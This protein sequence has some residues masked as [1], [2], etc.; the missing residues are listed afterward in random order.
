VS[1]RY[2]IS[3]FIDIDGRDEADEKSWAKRSAVSIDEVTSKWAANVA[4][5]KAVSKA[6]HEATS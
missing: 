4:E 6:V 1:G 3:F 5:I 2:R